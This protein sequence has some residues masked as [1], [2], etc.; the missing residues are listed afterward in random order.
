MQDR[1]DANVT[2]LRPSDNGIRHINLIEVLP[3][4]IFCHPLLIEMINFQISARTYHGQ[5]VTTSVLCDA[6]WLEPQIGT[7]DRYATLFK[8]GYLHVWVCTCKRT[9]IYLWIYTCTCLDM[10]VCMHVHVCMYMHAYLHVWDMCAHKYLH[11][12]ANT[13][14]CTPTY[15]THMYF[16][17]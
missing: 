10:Y 11:A 1:H 13:W 12:S 6:N 4:N 15:C 8:R 17:M 3:S 5:R 7:W 2:T 14:I 16:W 9:W